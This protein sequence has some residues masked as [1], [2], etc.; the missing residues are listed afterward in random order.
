M[1]ERDPIIITGLPRSGTSLTAG[2]MHLCGA[3]VGY[4]KP[5]TQYNPKGDFE[6]TEIQRKIIRPFLESI[7][8]CP[9]GLTKLPEVGHDRGA[10]SGELRSGV[11]SALHE[12]GYYNEPWI[13]KECK[14]ALFPHVWRDAFPNAKWVIVKRRDTAV[15][16]SCFRAHPMMDRMG[17]DIDR[18][19]DWLK[20]YKT[21]VESIDWADMVITPNSD[22]MS[23]PR[24]MREK[25]EELGLN[26]W[27][28]EEIK[29]FID[30]G[31]W[32]R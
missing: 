11:F 19:V 7:D 31:I 23:N 20:T 29:Q 6:N 21:H 4:Q 16:S 27:P 5:R 18:W 14:I 13:L 25:M 17:D 28:A 8:C 9:M 24:I 26:K 30:K 22:I 12:Q 1:E 3:W 2:I 32:N 10:L 15:L